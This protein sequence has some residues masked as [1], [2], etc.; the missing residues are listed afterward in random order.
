MR[1]LNKDEIITEDVEYWSK[2]QDKWLKVPS[3]V[4]GRNYDPDFYTLMRKA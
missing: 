1:N 4:V 3:H 2:S